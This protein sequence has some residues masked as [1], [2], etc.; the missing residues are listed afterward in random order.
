MHGKKCAIA[1]KTR[2]N[3]LLEGTAPSDPAALILPRLPDTLCFAGHALTRH[4]SL[5]DNQII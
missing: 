2:P 3:K 5:T 4:H 1:G